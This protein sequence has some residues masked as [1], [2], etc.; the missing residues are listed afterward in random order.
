M[1]FGV[2]NG[3]Q[4]MWEID[5]YGSGGQSN[6]LTPRQASVSFRLGKQASAKLSHLEGVVHVVATAPEEVIHIVG[7]VEKSTEKAVDLGRSKFQITQVKRDKRT[8][9]VSCSMETS[10]IQNNM[11]WNMA[12]QANLPEVDSFSPRST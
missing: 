5:G 12:V 4:V 10:N 9:A 6:G 3:N 1:V 2:F 7:D 11:S 8:V